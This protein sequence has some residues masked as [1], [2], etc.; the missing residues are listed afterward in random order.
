MSPKFLKT[1]RAAWASHLEKKRKMK[2]EAEM[3]AIAAQE[4][5]A[6]AEEDELEAEE[7]AGEAEEEQ[8]EE[9]EGAEEEQLG[10]QVDAGD[11]AHKKKEPSDEEKDKSAEAK[12]K[13]NVLQAGQKVRVTEE[14][15][16]HKMRY[17]E[18]GVVEKVIGE[19]V[20][21]LF[22]MPLVPVTMPLR[23][24]TPLPS[25]EWAKND[26][27]VGL[28]R[29]SK[30]TKI[31]CL[32]DSGLTD[33]LDAQVSEFDDEMTTDQSVS[34]WAAIVRENLGLLYD[35]ELFVLPVMLHQV[36]TG[37][38]SLGIVQGKMEVE[39]CDDIKAKRLRYIK[40]HY[41]NAKMTLVPVFANNHWTLLSVMKMDGGGVKVEYFDTLHHQNSA[42]LKKAHRGILGCGQ[43]WV[44]Y[45]HIAIGCLRR[46]L[47]IFAVVCRCLRNLAKL[48]K[49]FGLIFQAR[50]AFF[51]ILT[52]NL[53]K[54]LDPGGV[55]APRESVSFR[56][57][58]FFPINSA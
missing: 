33:P 17:G 41:E 36:V 23:L 16:V 35:R 46:F 37:G 45:V 55:F 2:F 53:Q 12:V 22:S 57:L 3:M 44:G 54:K 43:T 48:G 20:K 10:E 29:K 4:K 51:Q 32:V 58:L 13:V 38:E 30:V 40:Y 18:T 52:Q 34:L 7:K 11:E 39:V 50:W 9:A 28:V 56:F 27:L 14:D 47:P 31:D 8:L 21:V 25:K 42:C 6:E 19:K 49:I 15:L 24:L 26:G 5:A 1:T